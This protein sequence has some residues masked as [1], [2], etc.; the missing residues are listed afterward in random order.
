MKIKFLSV[1]LSLFIS[2]AVFSWEFNSSYESWG[3]I[4]FKFGNSFEMSN[5]G[6][7]FI[8]ASGFNIHAY[9][10]RDNRNLGLAIR[11]SCLFPVLER[12]AES[13]YDLQMDFFAGWVRRWQLSESFTV[14]GGLGLQFGY[15]FAFDYRSNTDTDQSKQVFLFGIAS[16][17]GVKY[18]I[19][20]KVYVNLGCLVP[21]FY[22]NNGTIFS[23]PEGR[24]GQGYFDSLSEGVLNYMVVSV[25]PYIGI[26]INT[27][28]FQ[29]EVIGKP[30]RE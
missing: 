8:A 27:Y 5:A 12:G 11:G 1:M 22:S 17:L 24:V 14:Y 18:D 9:T 13:N 30:R 28:S 21:W 23:Y 10:F 20:D 2:S 7:N 26:G 29:R 25:R 15:M 6:R 19:T 4:G 3:G 16:D